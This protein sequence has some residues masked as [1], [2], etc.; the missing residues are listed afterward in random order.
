MLKK[1]SVITSNQEV[2]V[3]T[4]KTISNKLLLNAYNAFDNNSGSNSLIFELTSN[5]ASISLYDED[6]EIKTNVI[7]L[8]N[9]YVNIPGNITFDGNI[10]SI[11]KNEKG[12]LEQKQF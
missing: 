10:N 12:I 6:T 11:S 1:L 8:N 2:G 7:E 9:N 3:L 4:S 5:E